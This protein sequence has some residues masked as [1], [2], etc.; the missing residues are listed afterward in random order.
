MSRII[1]SN[2]SILIVHSGIKSIATKTLNELVKPSIKSNFRVPFWQVDKKARYFMYCTDSD[3]KKALSIP[4]PSNQCAD[5]MMMIIIIVCV[6]CSQTYHGLIWSNGGWREEKDRNLFFLGQM[7][8]CYLFGAY[9]KYIIIYVR[10]P[11]ARTRDMSMKNLILI[12]STNH[13]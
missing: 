4:C 1:R 7:E 2:H 13:I 6:V 9:V 8:R 5:L 12:S 3:M 11:M 10:V